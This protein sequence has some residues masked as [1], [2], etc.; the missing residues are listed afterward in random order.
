M[1][2]ILSLVFILSLFMIMG[3]G[4]MSY[5]QGLVCDLLGDSLKNIGLHSKGYLKSTACINT[6]ILSN[7]LFPAPFLFLLLYTN[8]S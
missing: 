2:N 5:D 8:S 4:F 1:L 6:I 7:V 3:K